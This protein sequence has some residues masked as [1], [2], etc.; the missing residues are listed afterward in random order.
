MMMQRMMTAAAAGLGVAAMVAGC[1]SGEPAS[2]RY[3]EISVESVPPHSPAPRNART[4][5]GNQGLGGSAD[6]RGCPVRRFLGAGRREVGGRSAGLDVLRGGVEVGAC[7]LRR[8]AGLVAVAP[9]DLRRL[10]VLVVDADA[11]RQ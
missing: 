8:S 7:D 3:A 4:G 10:G 1:G 5:R 11:A 2:A 6:P 9:V